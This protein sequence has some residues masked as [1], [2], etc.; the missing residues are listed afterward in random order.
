NGVGDKDFAKIIEQVKA[1]ELVQVNQWP[2]IT[3]DDGPPFNFGHAVPTRRPRE[4]I[5][6]AAPADEHPKSGGSPLE[7]PH[8]ELKTNPARQAR[9]S[10]GPAD[11]G[12]LSPRPSYIN[13]RSARVSCQERIVRTGGTGRE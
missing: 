10:H 1:A 5:S 9:R 12:F 8:R 13:Y 11:R 4:R 7:Q 3:D 6:L 2:G